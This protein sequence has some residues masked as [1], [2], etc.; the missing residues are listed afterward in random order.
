[1][2]LSVSGNRAGPGP[3]NEQ[4][5]QRA[6]TR[7]WLAVAAGTTALTAAACGAAAPAPGASGAGPSATPARVRFT[8]Q[9]VEPPHSDA[10]RQVV[11]L[12]RERNPTVQVESEL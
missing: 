7:R 2:E 10:E 5:E 8:S 3:S 6:V 12:F 1:M 11:D 4:T 9:N